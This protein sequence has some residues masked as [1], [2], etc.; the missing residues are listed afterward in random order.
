MAVSFDRWSVPRCPRH[1]SQKK[2]LIDFLAASSL[3]DGWMGYCAFRD[4]YLEELGP[5]P[6]PAT[7][8]PALRCQ[9]RSNH[10]FLCGWNIPPTSRNISDAPYHQ[11]SSSF[12]SATMGPSG[13][14]QQRPAVIPPAWLQNQSRMSQASYTRE[15]VGRTACNSRPRACRAC[16]PLIERFRYRGLAGW[17]T[18]PGPSTLD[19]WLNSTTL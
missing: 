19:E 2:S 5:C 10:L 15:R 3:D 14:G 11:L 18:A 1:A 12:S 16:G 13:Q 8:G 17:S 4:R 9:A 7:S 6:R